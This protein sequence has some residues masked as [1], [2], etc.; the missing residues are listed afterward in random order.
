MRIHS[1]VSIFLVGLFKTTT[2]FSPSSTKRCNQRIQSLTHQLHTSPKQS[3]QTLL[4]ASVDGTDEP[5]FLQVESLTPSQVTEL[6]ELSFFQACFALSKGEFEPLKLFIVAVKTVSTKYPG[7]SAS[8]ITMT[9]DSVTASVRPLEPAERDLRETWIR[10]IYLMMSHVLDNFDGGAVDDDEVSRTYGPILDDLVA[11]HQSGLGLN[12]NR[13]VSSRKDMLLPPKEK[14]NILV[15]DDG[16]EDEDFVELS[17]VTQ[18]IRVLYTTLE[19][20]AEDEGDDE[21]EETQSDSK[22]PVGKKRKGSESSGKG[23]A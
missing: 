11:I 1:L 19:V 6:I 4:S 18:T 9:V 17:V 10:A 16:P 14:K 15:L 13:F 3:S 8:V 5:E 7:A 23:F 22:P 21:A 12:I 20:L 2:A